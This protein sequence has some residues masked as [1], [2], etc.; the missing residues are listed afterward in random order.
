M[1]FL[2]VPA[3]VVFGKDSVPMAGQVAVMGTALAGTGG[4]TLLLN[5]CVSPYVLRMAE[6]SVEGKS[7][8]TSGR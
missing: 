2:A 8:V 3:L 5:L 1:S 6:V 4:S 7:T